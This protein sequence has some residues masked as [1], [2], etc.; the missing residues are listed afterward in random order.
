MMS[1]LKI[2]RDVLESLKR[3]D[4]PILLDFYADWCGPCRMMAPVVEELAA[5]HPEVAV[6]KINTDEEMAL[7]QSFG[8]ISIPTLIVIKNGAETAR[9]IGVRP[10]ADLLA[11]LQ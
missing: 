5:E 10:K 3:E 2:N 1:I 4:R 7:A 11:A 8:I 9:F 6:G